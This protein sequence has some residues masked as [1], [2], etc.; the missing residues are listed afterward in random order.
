MHTKKVFH[1]SFKTFTLSSSRIILT[2]FSVLIFIG[3]S[4]YICSRS[5]NR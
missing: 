4:L 2:G 1:Y 3:Y 5:L